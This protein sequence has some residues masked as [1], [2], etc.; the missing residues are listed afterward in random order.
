MT[1]TN[2]I[3]AKLI[4]AAKHVK[5]DER[6][7]RV[8]EYCLMYY[9]GVWFT[10]ERF[11]AESDEEAIF[12]ADMA[13]KKASNRLQYALFCGNRLVKRYAEPSNPYCRIIA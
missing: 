5:I 4:E 12:D 7:L 8:K 9:V 10:S 11:C 13:E 3:S 1:Q 6:P 2:D